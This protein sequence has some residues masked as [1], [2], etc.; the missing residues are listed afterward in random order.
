MPPKKQ[1]GGDSTVKVSAIAN[2]TGLVTKD[3]SPYNITRD[4]IFIVGKYIPAPFSAGNTV[5]QATLTSSVANT[6]IPPVSGGGK[7]KVVKNK[8]TKSNKSTN[9]KKK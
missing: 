9:S 6:F 5:N 8:T 3:H 2:T 1:K 4:P 7:K